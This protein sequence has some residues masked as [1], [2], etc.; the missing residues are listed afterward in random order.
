MSLVRDLLGVT[1]QTAQGVL[2]LNERLLL[3]ESASPPPSAL[4][5]LSAAVSSPKD[6]T[7]NTALLLAKT[8]ATAAPGKL[9]KSLLGVPKDVRA[10]LIGGTASLPSLPAVMHLPRAKR[11]QGSRPVSKWRLCAFTNCARDDGFCLVHWRKVND[12]Q[13]LQLQQQAADLQAKETSQDDKAQPAEGG[14]GGGQVKTEIEAGA[15]EASADRPGASLRGVR[16]IPF[17]DRLLLGFLLTPEK[18]YP[19]AKF[20]V[21]TVQ[22]PLTDE[23]YNKYIQPLDSSWSRDE[24]FELWH[25][26]HKFDLHWPV[27]FDAFSASP[28]RSV[29][30]LKQRY[31]AVAKRLVIRQFEEKEEEEL[32]KGPA[33][34]NAV[35]ARLREEKQRHPLVRFNFNFAAECQRRLLLERQQRLG[36]EELEAEQMLQTQ[37]RAAEG[38]LKKMGRAREEQRKL[39]RRFDTPADSAPAVSASSF[40]ELKEPTCVTLSALLEETKNKR[41]SEKANALIDGYLSSMGV[42]PPACFT[43]NIAETYWGLRTEVSIMLHLRQRVEK[44]KEELS[45]WSTVASSLPPHAPLPPAV[46][47]SPAALAGPAAAGVKAPGMAQQSPQFFQT[48][49]PPGGSA[50]AL[51]DGG[52]DRMSAGREPGPRSQ[53][54][55]PRDLSLPPQAGVSR[56]PSVSAGRAP[57]GASRSRQQASLSPA[58]P[59]SSGSSASPSPQSPS[60]SPPPRAPAAPHAA[61]GVAGASS[62]GAA[63][64]APSSGPAAAG[65]QGPM[66]PPAAGPG[67][68]VQMPAMQ[69]NAAHHP[70]APASHGE[71]PS[72]Q[73]SVVVSVHVPPSH[74]Q[75]NAQGGHPGS[76]FS[77]PSPLP[78][79]QSPSP[80]GAVPPATAHP[81]QMGAGPLQR[82]ASGAAAGGAQG[83]PSLPASY[84][85]MSPPLAAGG[86][87][88][89][90]RS[91]P[92]TG[93]STPANVGS[94][95]SASP[96]PPSFPGSSHFPQ[97]PHGNFAQGNF[98]NAAPPPGAFP[99][100]MAQQGAGEAGQQG[101]P[102]DPGGQPGG[103]VGPGMMGMAGAGPTPWGVPQT[104]DMG[105]GGQLTAGQ[106]AADGMQGAYAGQMGMPGG[107][108]PGGGASRGAQAG[109]PQNK[110]SR[111]RGRFPPSANA[112][113]TTSPY[114]PPAGSP[115]APGGP[116]SPLPPSFAS[117]AAP[118]EMFHSSSVSPSPSSTPGLPLLSDSAN[119]ARQRPGAPDGGNA[120]AAKKPRSAS[121]KSQQVLQPGALN[122][123]GTFPPANLPPGSAVPLAGPPAG[124][125]PSMPGGVPSEVGAGRMVM[126]GP[127][128]RGSLG[129]GA[130]PEQ[131]LMAH[132]AGHMHAPQEMPGMVDHAQAAGGHNVANN[133]ASGVA[134]PPPMAHPGAMQAP[135]GG[136][137]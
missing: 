13:A 38:K 57:D 88:G 122:P 40:L 26:V 86:R 47:A 74:Y 56:C 80:H 59:A 137:A 120:R 10:A 77:V 124:P 114:P 128:S 85:G 39:Q 112:T 116:P 66:A 15:A 97:H 113:Q 62:H 51:P 7:M 104:G 87:A 8:G 132:P 9:A 135:S 54:Q 52:R 6:R 130:G 34:S 46:G 96:F 23:L 93:V 76:S 126:I 25:L 65:Q 61:T 136:G 103:T 105:P 127:G 131:G 129:P 29:E 67:G 123:G 110:A 33:A 24:T 83:D 70:G 36:L 84:P 78:S 53:P 35:L 89:E 28:G 2:Q 119:A 5:E 92:H 48:H 99:Q 3:H 22:P 45:Y 43:Y 81:T 21:K 14:D 12:Q 4:P 102:G 1:P 11:G 100:L 111:S 75:M 31:Y 20:N 125:G 49:F 91:A 63:H 60:L 79:S 18:D 41:V 42:A 90:E 19:F 16:R 115:P 107:N 72:G 64:P 133:V 73:S 106:G 117:S 55:A 37:I 134:H 27:I 71:T 50:H 69:A 82:G 95:P 58:P 109:N 118:G 32:A 30:E 44:L 17:Q 94:L 121:R 98:G 68:S 101:P 108:R